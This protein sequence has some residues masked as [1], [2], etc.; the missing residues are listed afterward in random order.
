M[1][2]IFVCFC[3]YLM[4]VY[5]HF[6]WEL[7]KKHTLLFWLDSVCCSA[8]SQRKCRW[9]ASGL[10]LHGCC[11]QTVW[12]RPLFSRPA[13]SGAAKRCNWKCGRDPNSQSPHCIPRVSEPPPTASY[14]NRP[15]MLSSAELAFKGLWGSC[16]YMFLTLPLSAPSFCFGLGSAH[17]L[18]SIRGVQ[19]QDRKSMRV[20]LVTLYFKPELCLYIVHYKG[21]FE[22]MSD[23][24]SYTHIWFAP[25]F[26]KI[27][28]KHVY[29]IPLT[30]EIFKASHC[31]RIN[32]EIHSFESITIIRLQHCKC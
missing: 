31:S 18:R 7:K 30:M 23:T 21:I 10:P 29:S 16:L 6:V 22:E 20:K 2:R 3:L 1:R 14:A 28:K 15:L 19:Q 8:R 13:R 24:S 17:A 9:S 25:Q 27:N 5:L 32:M 26:V 4:W 11:S 12:R